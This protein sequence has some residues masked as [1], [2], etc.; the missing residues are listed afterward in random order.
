M[1]TGWNGNEQ[2][3]GDIIRVAESYAAKL[4]YQ[5]VLFPL[6]I[7]TLAL[8]EVKRGTLGRRLAFLGHLSYSSYLLHFPLQL[9]LMALI[10]RLGLTSEV[11]YSPSSLILFFLLLIPASLASYFYFERPAQAFLRGKS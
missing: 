8:A 6:T 2:L 1:G 7:I 5:A 9:G 4:C 11:F 3:K 10:L